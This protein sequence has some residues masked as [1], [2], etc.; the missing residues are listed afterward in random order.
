MNPLARSSGWSSLPRYLILLVLLALGLVLW[1]N[2]FLPSSGG[3]GDTVIAL[4][5]STLITALILLVCTIFWRVGIGVVAFLILV[6]AL[7]KYIVDLGIKEPKFLITELMDS[8]W[9]ELSG[10]INAELVLWSVGLIVI[11]VLL[12]RGLSA[13]IPPHLRQAVRS[14]SRR[15]RIGAFLIVVTLV[16]AGFLIKKPPLEAPQERF[17]QAALWPV[18]PNLQTFRVMKGYFSGEM[19]FAKRIGQAPRAED[20]PSSFTPDPEGIVVVF[21]FGESVRAD[22]WGLNGYRR[23][24]TPLLADTPGVINFPDA[25]SFGT[26]T[27]VSAVGMMT[28]TSFHAPTPIGPSFVDFFH[29]HGFET[30]A[31][32]SSRP[33]SIQTRLTQAIQHKYLKRSE[34][35]D[36]IPMIEAAIPRTGTDNRFV[37]IYTEGNHFP[38]DRDYPEGFAKFKPDDHSRTHLAQDVDKLVNAYDNAVLY[39]D[40]FLAQ[41]IGLLQ[42]RRAILVYASDHGD[43]LG[44]NGKF[45]RGGTMLDQELRHIPF[46]IWTSPSYAMSNPGIVAALEINSNL[47]VSHDNIFPTIMSLAGIASP[48]V[49]PTLDLTARRVRSRDYEVKDGPPKGSAFHFE[50]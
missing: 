47:K 12:V 27:Q 9:H 40:A 1:L 38:Y 31:F 48:A 21:V 37:F 7:E 19:Q 15:N 23:N 8:S 18:L 30:W 2:R 16:A 5:S 39:T 42:D 32:N 25:L 41:L 46:F 36:L 13:A 29:K 45:I 6:A 50:R 24:T 22:H 34:A 10:F 35:M 26:Y 20:I 28:P 43:A 33:T 44:E 11:S 3:G 14:M 4:A 17:L 49:D